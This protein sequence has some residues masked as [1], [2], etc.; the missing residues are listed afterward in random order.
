MTAGPGVTVDGSGSPSSPYVISSDAAATPTPVQAGD[1][2][3]VDTTVSGTGTAGDPYVVSAAVI[4]DPA[5]PG[6]GS[7]LVHS[8][9]D[10]LFVECADVRG[11]LSAGDGIGYDPATGVIEA[12]ISGDAGNQ[13]TIGT[14]GGLY[15]PVAGATALEATD[16]PTVDMTVT[17]T[18]TAGDPYDVSA[19][20]IVDPAPPGG[21][22]NLLQA[23]PDG[24]FAEIATECGLTGDGSAGAPLAA[25]VGAWGYPCD[26]DTEAGQVYCDSTGQLRSEPRP[27]ATYLSDLVDQAYPS[28]IVP[29]VTEATVVTRSLSITNPDPCRDAFVIVEIEVDVDLRLPVNATAMYGMGGDDTV[30]FENRGNSVQNNIHWQTTKAY[31]RTIAPGGT[32][33]EPLPVTMGLGSNGATYQRIQTIIRAFVFNL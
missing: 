11:C 4:L 28:L 13:T 10:G 12:Q 3:T 24:L 17:G 2:P 31:H 27:R 23:G 25:S 22:P 26:L 29:T 20:V 1:T 14:D 5:P 16:T 7:N 8:G 6:G 21:G 19:A 30:Y 32:L 18:G 15:T 33:V 9:P